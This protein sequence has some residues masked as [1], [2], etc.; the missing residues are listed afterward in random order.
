LTLYNYLTNESY[1]AAGISKDIVK[2]SIENSLCFG[3]F[4]ND[5]QIGFARVISDFAT[6]AYIA[7]VFIS[8]SHRGKGLSKLIMKSIMEYPSCKSLGV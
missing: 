1:W 6:F 5:E 7:D 8:K 4:F 2:H 3:V